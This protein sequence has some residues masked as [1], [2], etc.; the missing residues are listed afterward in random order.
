MTGGRHDWFRYH[1]PPAPS[2][3]LRDFAV[4]ETRAGR[5]AEAQAALRELD[6]RLTYEADEWG[7]SRD[8]LPTIRVQ[9]RFA[10]A[11]PISVWFGVDEA[12]RF[13][14]VREVRFRGDP[15]GSDR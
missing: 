7:E 3:R 10:T 8:Y 6:Y 12:N 4:R 14:Q 13:V 11:G 2:D 1:I 15:R 9:M 5:R